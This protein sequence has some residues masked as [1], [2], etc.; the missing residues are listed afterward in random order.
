[1][2]NVNNGRIQNLSQAKIAQLASWNNQLRKHYRN[3]Y[4]AS[5]QLPGPNVPAL[6]GNA[7]AMRRNNALIRQATQN[8]NGVPPT[9]ANANAVAAIAR[10]N[11][12]LANKVLPAAVAVNNNAAKVAVANAN[13]NGANMRRMFG[14]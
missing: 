8:V 10:E 13:A 1:M 14:N 12:V 5:K 9:V 3:E 2:S 11:N 6:P 7:A 4:D